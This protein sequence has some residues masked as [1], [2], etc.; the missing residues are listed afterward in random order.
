MNP[1]PL[2]DEPRLVALLNDPTFTYRRWDERAACTGLPAT[3]DPYF[4]DDGEIPPVEA[5]APCLAC[6]VAHECLATALIHE[7]EEGL[8]FGWWG[9]CSPDERELLAEHIGL[10]TRRV[11]IDRRTPADLARILRAQNR[12]VPSIA[13]EL[14]CTERTVYRYLA[15]TA[16]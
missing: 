15:G 16:A 1:I 14:G 12:T 13:A 11:E 7:A 2:V 6:P 8:R 4:P 9:G 10:H 5:M 3:G